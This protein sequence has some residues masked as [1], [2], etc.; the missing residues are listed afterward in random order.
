MIKF[1][2]QFVL[3]FPINRFR[4]Y[5]SKNFSYVKDLKLRQLSEASEM[6]KNDSVKKVNDNNDVQMINK[7]VENDIEQNSAKSNVGENIEIMKKET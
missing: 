1:F 6:Y 3:I 7:D 5:Y 4:R 2:L